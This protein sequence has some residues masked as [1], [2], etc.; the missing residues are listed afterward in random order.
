[1][2]FSVI[3]TLSSKN[4]HKKREA[5]AS[6]FLYQYVNFDISSAE[7]HAFAIGLH[8]QVNL[9]AFDGTAGV[10][11]NGYTVARNKYSRT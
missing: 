6:L 4:R 7:V 9:L 11:G 5:E 3:A 2:A 1:M 10:G 8:A